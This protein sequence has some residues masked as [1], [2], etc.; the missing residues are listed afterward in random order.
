[1]VLT[2]CDVTELL[3]KSSEKASETPREAL[4]NRREVVGK[5][6][7]EPSLEPFGTLRERVGKSSGTP[8]KSSGILWKV[9]GKTL[10]KHLGK[11]PPK[12]GK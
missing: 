12:R 3:G 5:K 1:M 4:G 8:R 10:R 7:E 9:I 6:P 11:K 2:S